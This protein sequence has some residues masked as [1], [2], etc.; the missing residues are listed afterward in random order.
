MK[1]KIVPHDKL[2]HGQ[3]Y[4]HKLNSMKNSKWSICKFCKSGNDFFVGQWEQQ[5]FGY[6]LCEDSVLAGPI[7]SPDAQ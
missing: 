4:W 3:W 6:D 7:P 2:I 5:L 1:Y